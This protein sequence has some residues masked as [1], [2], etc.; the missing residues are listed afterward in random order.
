M[1][2]PPASW[3]VAT[4]PSGSLH[5]RPLL[6]EE[7]S[8]TAP[9]WLH[10]MPDLAQA[11]QAQQ[12]RE[13]RVVR[14]FTFVARESQP[15]WGHCTSSRALFSECCPIPKRI[16]RHRSSQ[17][18]ASGDT[19]TRAC[20]NSESVTPPTEWLSMA[21]K[22]AFESCSPTPRRSRA[23]LNS[24]CVSARS[25]ETSWFRR[26]KASCSDR[27]RL[28]NCCRNRSR[29]WFWNLPVPSRF[30]APS[31]V[32]LAGLEARSL[33]PGEGGGSGCRS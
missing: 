20:R 7:P 13:R 10:S 22:I 33:P 1:A 5:L 28:S 4:P 17:S 24:V 18:R 3:T 32:R 11:A 26:S 23:F 21:A 27:K 6:G 15:C 25:L 14:R 12:P 9:P 2:M 29:M 19:S 30:G 31:P 8:R 16:R